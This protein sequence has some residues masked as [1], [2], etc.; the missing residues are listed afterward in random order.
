MLTTKVEDLSVVRLKDGR[1]GTVVLVY[2]APDEK[3]AYEVESSAKDGD[4]W[5]VP[6]EQIDRVLWTP[7]QGR[8]EP[9]DLKAI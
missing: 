5:T 1:K 6:H 4:L 2:D 3:L 7:A 9:G 8:L